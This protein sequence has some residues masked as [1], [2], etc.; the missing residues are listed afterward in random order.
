MV[1][2]GFTAVTNANVLIGSIFEFMKRPSRLNVGVASDVAINA[3]NTYTLTIG[4]QLV[5]SAAVVFPVVV[6]T[7]VS[8]IAGILWP[9]NFMVQN[10]PAL[11]GDRIVLSIARA[12]GN[13]F[14]CVQ[15]TEVA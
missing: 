3:G 14:W 6:N 12:A 15:V 5:A 4:D 9:D 8:F 7:N 11:A 1:L 2:S 13:I 10:E